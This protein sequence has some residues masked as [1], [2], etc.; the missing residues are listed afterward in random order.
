MAKHNDHDAEQAVFEPKYSVKR[1]E[2]AIFV[3]LKIFTHF[4]ALM[5]DSSFTTSPRPTFMKT[6]F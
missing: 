6:A 1:S 3:E 4:I 2:C 5:M